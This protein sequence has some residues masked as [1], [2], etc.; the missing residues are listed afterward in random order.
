M[1]KTHGPE[2][3]ILDEVDIEEFAKRGEPLP[4]AK[5]YRLRID[6]HHYV[7]DAEKLTG[8]ELLALAGKTPA[9]YH[10]RQRMRGGQVRPVTPEQVVDLREP[11]V[12]RFMTIPKENTDGM[13][14]ETEGVLDVR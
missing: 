6:D 3:P 5:V 1:E 9:G 2:E 14:G 11:G 10:L 13:K 8:A 4:L 7:T 12:E